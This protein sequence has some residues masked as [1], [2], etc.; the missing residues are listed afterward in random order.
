MRNSLG[1]SVGSAGV[2]SA[3]VTT[4]DAGSQSVEYRTISADLDSHSDVGDLALSAIGLMTTQVPDRRIEPD[5]IAVAYRT[6]RQAAAV[7]SAAKTQ[8]QA[9]RLVPETL[10]TLAYLRS[11]GLVDRY[12]CIALADLGASGL[13]VTIVDPADGTVSFCD[14]TSRVRG[15][16]ATSGPT[17]G[18][19]SRV[20]KFVTD[21]I[22]HADR[23]PAAVVVVGGGGNI[24]DVGKGLDAAFDCAVIVVPEPEAATAKGV[25]LLAGSNARQQ[26]P[27]VTGSGSRLSAPLIAAFVLGALV[28]G[29]GVQQMIPDSAENFSPA[30]SLVETPGESATSTVDPI[31][32]LVQ[33]EQTGIPSVDPTPTPTVP[34]TAA[35]A[36][37]STFETTTPTVTTTSPTPTPTSTTPEPTETPKQTRPWIPPRWPE[38]PSWL[39]EDAK[40]PRLPS[41]EVPDFSDLEDFGDFD[42][43][44][45]PHRRPDTRPGFAPPR[46]PDALPGF[47]RPKPPER[48]SAVSPEPDSPTPQVLDSSPS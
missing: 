33:P 1:I 17:N 6:D 24:P 45:G 20:A 21:S 9:I 47:S 25:A 37:S 35:P 22:S 12:D 34:A 38:E 14:R 30:G 27:V 29:Y 42:D 32:S 4:D 2:C 40:P 7:R 15:E 39:P 36:P 8:R 10:A 13:T 11:T 48:R 46:L 19:G 16:T 5:A 3:L 43:F 44:D 26:F 28:I 18:I 31:P 41:F 23:R